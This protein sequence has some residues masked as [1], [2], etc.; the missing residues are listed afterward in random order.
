LAVPTKINGN[1]RV[2][3]C[4][5]MST[6]RADADGIRSIPAANQRSRQTVNLV[7]CLL[8]MVT[9]LMA[10]CTTLQPMAGN[11]ETLRSELRGGEAV[12]P[13]DKVRVV[14]RDGLSRMLIVTALDQNV[15]KGHPEGIS[16]AEAVVTIP[17]DDIV[18]MEGK[19]VSVGKTAAY[20]G[21]IT[22]GAALT[23]GIAVIIAFATMW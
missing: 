18:F 8:L 16:T 21:G 2:R 20:A 15:L 13:G 17:I 3:I 11:A 22:V 5:M 12:K 14:S 23:M 9:I 6:K 1:E 7:L 10:G 4:K 19:Q